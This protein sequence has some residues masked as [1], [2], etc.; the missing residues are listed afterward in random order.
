MM[1]FMQSTHRAVRLAT[2]ALALAVCTPAAYS[3]QPSPAA[4]AT[5]KEV[6]LAAGSGALFNPLIAGVVEQAKLLF[7]Q[8]D[9]NLTKD[10]NDVAAKMRADL[11]PRYDELINEMARQYATRFTEQELQD[12]LAFNKSPLGKKIQIEQPIIVDAS[13][14]FAQ[15]WANSLSDEVIG[16]MREELKK[17]GH[18]L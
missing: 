4:L 17:R 8:Q 1:Q 18:A 9:P 15:N 7:L 2:V 6:V 13:L 14:K 3:Q 12:F 5:A 10:A 11:A 16:R